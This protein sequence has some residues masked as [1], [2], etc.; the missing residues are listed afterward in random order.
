M[1]TKM[2]GQ[3]NERKEITFENQL[4]INNCCLIGLDRWWDNYH[5]SIHR[6]H[7]IE[8]KLTLIPTKKKLFYRKLV[9]PSFSI[10]VLQSN[11][12][13][14]LFY[15]L[16]TPILYS[17]DFGHNITLAIIWK[18]NPPTIGLKQTMDVCFRK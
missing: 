14:F 7:W 1:L 3:A 18:K 15:L 17:I 6:W 9:V 12:N 10:D 4:P 2:F 8:R 13:R 5:S 16:L 11:E